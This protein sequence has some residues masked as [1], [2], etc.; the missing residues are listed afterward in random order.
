MTIE[1]IKFYHTIKEATIADIKS[2]LKKRKKFY[3][4]TDFPFK[5]MTGIYCTYQGKVLNDYLRSKGY[6]FVRANKIDL[7]SLTKNKING[8]RNIIL[9]F[10]SYI[11]YKL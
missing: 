11:N 10:S 5:Q 7:P 3:L 4:S 1:T 9:K 8:N 2:V 6:I